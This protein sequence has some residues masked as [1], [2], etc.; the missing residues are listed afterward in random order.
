MGGLDPLG[1]NI[2]R[3]SIVLFM[4]KIVLPSRIFSIEFASRGTLHRLVL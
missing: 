2:S 4:L 1:S 3:F